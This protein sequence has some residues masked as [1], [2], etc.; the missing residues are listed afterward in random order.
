MLTD[1]LQDRELS[2]AFLTCVHRVLAH[3]DMMRQ[4]AVRWAEIEMK[5]KH[6]D[7]LEGAAE[8]IKSV[9]IDTVRDLPEREMKKVS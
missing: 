5:F 6:G 2:Q 3:D 4:E 8:A 7:A 9:D 1:N